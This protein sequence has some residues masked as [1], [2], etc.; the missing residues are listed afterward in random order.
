MIWVLIHT[1]AISDGLTC[2]TECCL[3]HMTPVSKCLSEAILF[4]IY[5]ASRPKSCWH[6]L[7][8]RTIFYV[9]ADL[10]SSPPRREVS[11]EPNPAILLLSQLRT[12]GAGSSCSA[13]KICKLFP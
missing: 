6:Q 3:L 7:V 10:T 9:I 11:F 2:F 13:P 12:A 1:S 5:K 4:I 8:A